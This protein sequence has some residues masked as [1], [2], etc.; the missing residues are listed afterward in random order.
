MEAHAL[1]VREKNFIDELNLI[2]VE[3]HKNAQ[4]K[5]EQ[6]KALGQLL[7]EFNSKKDIEMRAKIEKDRINNQLKEIQKSKLTALE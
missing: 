6:E 4:R 3:K 2:K 1:R 5:A 7:E